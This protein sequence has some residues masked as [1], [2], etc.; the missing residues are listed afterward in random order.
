VFVCGDSS[1]GRLGIPFCGKVSSPRQIPGLS[2]FVIKNVAVHS[3]GKHAMALSF[4]GKVIFI[5]LLINFC[6]ND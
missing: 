5:L 2:Q 3:G 6:R 4:D 1:G